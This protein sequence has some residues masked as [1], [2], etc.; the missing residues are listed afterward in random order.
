MTIKAVFWNTDTIYGADHQRAALKQA[1]E[2]FAAE[3]FNQ[4]ALSPRVT[5]DLVQGL[6]KTGIAGRM[7]FAR[8]VEKI[9]E[10]TLKDNLGSL[11]IMRAIAKAAAIAP[12]E[13]VVIT[14]TR[15]DAQTAAKAGMQAICVEGGIDDT[16]FARFVVEGLALKP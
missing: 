8:S 14:D 13:V 2:I 15:A 1:V 16:N 4:V 7:I 11:N 6:D 12:Q 9:T 10:E 3:Q 5:A